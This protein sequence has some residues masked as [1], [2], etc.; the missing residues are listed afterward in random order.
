MFEDCGKEEKEGSQGPPNKEKEKGENTDAR[1]MQ[2]KKKGGAKGQLR[3]PQ[4]N[5]K[6]IKTKA[7]TQGQQTSALR[8]KGEKTQF[9]GAATFLPKKFK[10]KKWGTLGGTKQLGKDWPKEKKKIKSD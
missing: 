2:K 8:E 9:R 7:V 1:T 5:R 6:T 3:E 10:E 4:R